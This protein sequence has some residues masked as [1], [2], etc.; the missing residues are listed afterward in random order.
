LQALGYHWP[1]GDATLL[2]LF[3][4]NIAAGLGMMQLYKLQII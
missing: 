3:G 2:A 4:L 1:L